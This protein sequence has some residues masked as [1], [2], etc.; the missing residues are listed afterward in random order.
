ME[1]FWTTVGHF[2]ILMQVLLD[3]SMSNHSLT[4]YMALNTMTTTTVQ[5]S[6]FPLNQ[7]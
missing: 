3:M 6:W 2:D 4:L 5:L 7:P 1:M